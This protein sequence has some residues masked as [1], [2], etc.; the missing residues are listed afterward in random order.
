MIKTVRVLKEGPGAW[1]QRRSQS[2]SVISNK[3]F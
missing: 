2:A 1:N 3:S